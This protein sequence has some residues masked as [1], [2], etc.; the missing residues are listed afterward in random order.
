MTTTNEAITAL[1]KEAE[2][3]RQNAEMFLG[4]DPNSYNE[5]TAFVVG[6][7]MGGHNGMNRALAVVEALDP[8]SDDSEA[9]LPTQGHT[10][11]QTTA[12]NRWDTLKQ[13]IKS[14]IATEAARDE[15]DARKAPN[16]YA[17]N[18]ACGRL[19]ALNRVLSHMELVELEEFWKETKA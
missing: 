2:Y 11:T 7:A 13:W 5:R 14:E 19:E 16:L 15:A 10:E 3:A 4:I 12:S 9:S 18:S 17:Y 8:Q 1:K 6:Y